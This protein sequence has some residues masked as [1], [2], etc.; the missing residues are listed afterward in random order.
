M[1]DHLLDAF[2][3]LREHNFTP[4]R[5][6]QDVMERLEHPK[7]RIALVGK[8]QTGKST[9]INQA[10][11]NG[12]P[13]HQEDDGDAAKLADAGLEELDSFMGA[14]KAE[15]TT[16]MGLCTTAVV[17]EVAY[18]DIPTLEV[19][20]WKVKTESMEID[21]GEGGK[22]TGK[23]EIREMPD[24]PVVTVNPTKKDLRAATTASGEARLAKSRATAYVRLLWPREELAEY[25]LVD[26]PGIDDPIPEL[27]NNTT[28]RVI[29]ESD[30]AILVLE[31]G[32]LDQVEMDFLRSRVFGSGLTR[33]LALVSYK[34]DRKKLGDSARGEILAAIRAQLRGIGRESIP[35]EIYCYDASVDGVRFNTPEKLRN[36]VLEYLRE[37]VQAS[38]REKA[39]FMLRTAL[40]NALLAVKTEEA[41]LRKSEDERR[42]L[43]RKIRAEEEESSRRFDA[44]SDEILEEIEEMRL[45]TVQKTRKG[46][47]DIMLKNLNRFDDCQTISEAQQKIKNLE[48]SL[49]SDVE[50]LLFAIG[51]DAR[52]GLR[53]LSAKYGEKASAAIAPLRETLTVEL[54]LNPGFLASIPET[55]VVVIDYVISSILIPGPFFTDILLRWLAGKFEGLGNILPANLVRNLIVRTIR[56]NLTKQMEGATEVL[57]EKINGVFST[58]QEQTRGALEK[59]WR[60]ERDAVR[61]GL[62]DKA[63]IDIE[64]ETRR[65]SKARADLELALCGIESPN[66]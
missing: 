14:S 53:A 43:V 63:A 40:R 42:E 38:R 46:L 54:E 23:A 2:T 10:F 20:P 52:K 11:L 47:S 22:T 8:F 45:G 18:G 37:N 6:L 49:K 61:S 56:A 9:L 66:S 55:L 60:G 36:H 59:M 19:Y 27:V 4:S 30:T 31:P 64:A 13:L 62:A 65:L 17:T 29:P 50:E 25:T 28:Y 5:E 32:M 51:G 12:G 15:L 57:S 26:T 39:A 48:K 35:V 44:L 33:I 21:W 34:P 24:Q 16:G 3:V 41:M 58:I 7:Y 1:S